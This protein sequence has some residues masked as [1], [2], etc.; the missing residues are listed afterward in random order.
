MEKPLKFWN[1]HKFRF[2]V[3]SDR[4][5]TWIWGLCDQEFEVKRLQL[6]KA[7]DSY[8]VIV[9][10]EIWNNSWS[11]LLECERSINCIKCPYSRKHS[12]HSFPVLKCL[13]KAIYFCKIRILVIQW[14]R[15]EIYW[16]KIALKSYHRQ[17]SHSIWLL[18]KTSGT[19]WRG[20]V[21]KWTRNPLIHFK[22]RS[23][24]ITA[25]NLAI[26]SRREYLSSDQ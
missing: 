4:G 15:L 23:F 26:N 7:H 20:N 22:C 1:T 17:A 9:R 19:Y 6:I 3:F 12:F 14:K 25:W 13:N 8:S 18:L 2:N 5:R 11:E 24:E 10:G 16:M 21:I